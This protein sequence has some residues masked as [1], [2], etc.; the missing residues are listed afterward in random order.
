MFIMS[1]AGFQLRKW[2]SNDSELQT[3]FD[4][5]EKPTLVSKQD[6]SSFASSQF[7]TERKY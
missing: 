6:D 2:T 5:Q 7:G 1:K 3:F 4:S